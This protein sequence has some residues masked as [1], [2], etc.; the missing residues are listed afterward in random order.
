MKAYRR[1]VFQPVKSTNTDCLG[2]PEIW[3]MTSCGARVGYVCFSSSSVDAAVAQL[4]GNEYFLAI[5]NEAFVLV[6]GLG[7]PL[8]VIDIW[9]KYL[10][11]DRRRTA[12]VTKE[13]RAGRRKEEQ[14]LKEY[15]HTLEL[16][17]DQVLGTGV[18]CRVAAEAG[19][20]FWPVLRQCYAEDDEL[21]VYLRRP[22]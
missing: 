15:V 21:R 5:F 11:Q 17:L 13:A 22:C 10:E 3:D 9:L 18:V 1:A 16:H 6:P 20:R 2:L 7:F 8:A 14:Q 12:A 4:V 19:D